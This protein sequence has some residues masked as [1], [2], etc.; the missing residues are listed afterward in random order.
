MS[1]RFIGD[2][3]DIHV[4]LKE[5]CDECGKLFKDQIRSEKFLSEN[6]ELNRKL[7][8]PA[9]VCIICFYKY[10]EKS[11]HAVPPPLR[12]YF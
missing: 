12:Q 9:R 6:R 3:L 5:T 7:G 4:P 2:G 1:A 11:G 8:Y 10:Y